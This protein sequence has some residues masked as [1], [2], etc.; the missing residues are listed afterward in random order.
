MNSAIHVFTLDYRGFGLSTGIPSEAGLIT[1]G[2]ALV[3]HVLSLGIP[4][5]RI[6]LLGQSLGTQVA[7]AVALHFA[8]TSVSMHLLPSVETD[9]NLHGDPATHLPAPKEPVDFA[10]VILVASFPSLKKLLVTYRMS[11]LV[12]LLSPLRVT[13]YFQALLLTHIHESWNTSSRLA[14]LTT[15]GAQ[16]GRRL[17]LHIMHARNDWDIAYK[18]GEENFRAAETALITATTGE[19]KDELAVTGTELTG[20]EEGE[21]LREELWLLREG[22]GG[23]NLVWELLMN[24][25]EYFFANQ[26]LFRVATDM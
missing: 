8:D 14:A 7:S 4:S 22:G 10:A 5:S 20:G 6:L 21:T 13:P 9:L 23:V 16:P 19:G 18:H 11:G 25:G 26:R 2:V 12:P 3:N 15:A 24:G 17:R 1:D